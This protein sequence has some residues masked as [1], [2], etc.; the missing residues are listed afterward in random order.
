MAE[1]HEQVNRLLEE[2]EHLRTRLE[3]RR[4]EQSREPT[5]PFPGSHPGKGKEV[6]ALDDID[7]PADN[8]LSFV[9]SLLPHRPPSPNAMKAKSRKGHITDQVVSQGA[10]CGE[11]C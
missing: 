2:N 3:A 4:A 8:E 10:G 1:L 5:R 11:I 7:L 9:S 6:V